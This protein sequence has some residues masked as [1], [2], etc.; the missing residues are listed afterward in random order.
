MECT[1]D[2]GAR[3]YAC[4]N[5]PR[6]I[7]MPSPTP[8]LFTSAIDSCVLPAIPAPEN[9]LLLAVLHQFEQS[10]RWPADLLRDRQI[11]QLATV[12]A[13][14]RR[15]V[16]FYRDR[17]GPK[18]FAG[19]GLDPDA[20]AAVPVLTRA[21]VQSKA[22]SLKAGRLP[23][24]HAHTGTVRTSG[25]TGTAV[26]VPTTSVMRMMW[27]ASALRDHYWNERDESGRVASIRIFDDKAKAGW[28]DGIAFRDWGAPVSLLHRTG[29]AVGLSIHTDPAK[30][31]EFLKRHRPDYLLTFPSNA[32]ALAE[33][34]LAGALD[35]PELK[36]IQLVSEALDPTVRSRIERAW[37]AKV[38]D[39][40][41]AQEVG[42]IALQCPGHDHYHVQ[43]ENVLVEVVD[44]DGRP[45]APGGVGRVLVT[46]LHN[47]AMP[48]IRYEI[49]DY[50]EVGEDCACGRTLPV[51]RRILGRVRNMLVLPGGERRWP[52]LAAPF[53]RDIAPVVQHQIVQHD[54]QR[55]EARLVVERAL[56]PAEEAAL[57][58]VIVER[59]G[60]PFDVAFSYPARIERDRSGKFEEF[61]SA[62]ASP[63]AASG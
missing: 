50:A 9:A 18:P 27:F 8:R 22:A 45:C 42:Y 5:D 24:G 16:P 54:L 53:Y 49:G 30:Q 1:A 37:G 28:P 15:Q 63:A 7:P 46:A 33:L 20:W 44:D 51:L 35:L 41:S 26:A 43:A 61:V 4:A 59:L 12:W 29:S 56:T 52:S 11:A 32:A 36:E 6:R 39:V 38:T 13:H 48:L 19:T 55:V 60:H 14:A 57:R 62:V 2:C 3:G 31:A 23:L 58:D 47:F 10:E 40:Y 21:Q 17:P 34:A 25:A